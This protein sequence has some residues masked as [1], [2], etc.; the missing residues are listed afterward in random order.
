MVVCRAMSKGRNSTTLT[1][2]ITDSAYEQLQALA[3]ERGV[4]V[5]YFVKE[6]I[7]EALA[8][9]ELAIIKKGGCRGA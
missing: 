9:R 4:S 5:G 2:R 8:A 6:L 1:I 7:A 3:R